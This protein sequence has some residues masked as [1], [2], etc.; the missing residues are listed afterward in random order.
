[1]F[2]KIIKSQRGFSLLEMVI[3]LSIIGILASMAVPSYRYSLIKTKESVLKDSLFHMRDVIDQYY[4]DKGKYPY[5]F[6]DLVIEGYLRKMPIDPITNSSSSWRPIMAEFSQV[7]EEEQ[8][9][10]WDVHSGSDDKA[11]DGSIYST[12]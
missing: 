1:M 2:L 11:L 4:A 7:D 3:V 5:E 6:N 9:G 12:W 10:I 8:P